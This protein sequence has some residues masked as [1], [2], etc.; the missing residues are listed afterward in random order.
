MFLHAPQ[1]IRGLFPLRLPGRRAHGDEGLPAC[2]AL[3]GQHLSVHSSSLCVSNNP[4]SSRSAWKPS[5]GGCSFPWR[6]GSHWFGLQG[7]SGA[8]SLRLWLEEGGGE[9]QRRPP[10]PHGPQ[11][12]SSCRHHWGEGV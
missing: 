4:V 1:Q 2:P 10:P 3:G 7:V 8:S 11:P 5:R 12:C 6:S 9:R